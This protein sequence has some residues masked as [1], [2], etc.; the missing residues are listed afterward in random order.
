MGVTNVVA[1]SLGSTNP[2][3][4]VRATIDGSSNRHERGAARLSGA[5]AG[6]AHSHA[7][8]PNRN[9]TMTAPT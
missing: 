3:N 8:H 2:Y 4:M 1:K 5:G 7:S 6:R 9:S